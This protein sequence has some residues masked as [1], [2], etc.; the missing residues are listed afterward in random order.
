MI[1]SR[2]IDFSDIMWQGISSDAKDFTEK[3]LNYNP[4]ER[5]TAIEALAHPFIRK[6][7]I[8]YTADDLKQP[9]ENL[10]NFK[11]GNKFKRASYKFI[12]GWLL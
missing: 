12:G 4:Q 1:R 11:S 5:L 3:L 7:W 8:K 6:Y 2:K 9:V 10:R